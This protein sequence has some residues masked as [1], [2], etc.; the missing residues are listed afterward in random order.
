MSS[1]LLIL[2]GTTASIGFL[3]TLLGPDHYLPFIVMAR[4]GRWSF[5][6]T[7]WVTILCGTGHV[8]GSLLLGIT[9][10]TFG[11]AVTK[12]DALESFRG[13]FA[14]WALIAFGLLYACWGLRRASRNRPHE[15]LHVHAD[16][17]Q[18]SHSHIHT[19]RH[20][21]VHGEDGP[22]K[23]TP[24][25]L[26]SIFVFGPCE[27]LI[28]LLMYPAAKNSLGGLTLVAGIFYAVTLVTMLGIVFISTMGVNLVPLTRMERYAHVLAGGSIC[29]CGLSI[30]IFGV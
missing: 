19:N 26:F 29:L 23:A 6:K 21:H 2:A 22:R 7:L 5:Y 12:L 30:K 27:P 3:H 16:G 8:A 17:N 13:D 20:A 4:S 28:P 11:I 9:G 10:I 1:E 15:H 18:H 14:A 25:V 24:W